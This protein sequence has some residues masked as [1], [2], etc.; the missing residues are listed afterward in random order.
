MAQRTFN[1]PPFGYQ[2]FGYIADDITEL[3]SLV[4]SGSE[5]TTASNGLTEV[6]N[7]VQLGG[8]LGC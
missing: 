6:G 3:F 8:T 4:N 1:N 7:D 5:S 2:I